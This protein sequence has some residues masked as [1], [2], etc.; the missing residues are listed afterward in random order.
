MRNQTIALCEWSKAHSEVTVQATSV[1]GLRQ[2]V[3]LGMGRTFL[4]KLATIGPFAAAA[5]TAI[6]P[7]SESPPSRA[8]LLIWRRSH[9]RAAGRRALGQRREAGLCCGKH[10]GG[11]QFSPSGRRPFALA[12]PLSKGALLFG[13]IEP[14][15]HREIARRSHPDT[16]KPRP[17]PNLETGQ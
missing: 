14:T 17:E 4:P 6:R 5:P 13:L 12:S 11:L 8:L 15:R 7:F 2:M 3:S 9:P 10:T 16:K 1:E